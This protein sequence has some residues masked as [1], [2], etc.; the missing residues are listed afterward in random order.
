MQNNFRTAVEVKFGKGTAFENE[1]VVPTLL[2]VSEVVSE[3]LN[4]IERLVGAR[5]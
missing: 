4:A 1:P 2:Q 5:N 3:A